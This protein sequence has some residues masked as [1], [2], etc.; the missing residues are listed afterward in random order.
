M[1]SPA[2]YN[3][4]GISLENPSGYDPLHIASS[5]GHQAI[6][7]VL[8]DHD[9]ELITTYGQSNATALVS[10]TPRGHADVVDQLLAQDPKQLELS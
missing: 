4:E 7:R 8:L 2:L 3:K 10:A 1:G 6:V 9:S 5:H